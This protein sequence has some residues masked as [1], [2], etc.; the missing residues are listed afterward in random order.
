MDDYDTRRPA[1]GVSSI[2]T[3]AGEVFTYEYGLFPLR[4]CG[5]GRAVRRDG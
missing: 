3:T 1:L 5:D 2:R 4:K